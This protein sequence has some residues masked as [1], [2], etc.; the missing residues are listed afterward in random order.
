MPRNIG[1]PVTEQ[2]GEGVGSGPGTGKEKV[3]STATVGR[4]EAG[5]RWTN[6]THGGNEISQLVLATRLASQVP[7]FDEVSSGPQVVDVPMGTG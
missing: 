5:N 2:S 1:G 6:A 4:S 3:C 7:R